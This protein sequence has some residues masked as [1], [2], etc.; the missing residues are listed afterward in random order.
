M[1]DTFIVKKGATSPSIIYRVT[2]FDGSSGAALFKMRNAGTREP[3]LSETATIT[4][5]G[6][7]TLFEYDWQVGDTDMM[8]EFEGEFHYS[9]AGG[10]L[11]KLPNGEMIPISIITAI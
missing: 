1:S 6:A 11:E 7:D 3:V 8:G 10:A 9:Y 4:V 2:N 5:D